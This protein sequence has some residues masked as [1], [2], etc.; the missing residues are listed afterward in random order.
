MNA[1][2]VKIPQT[3]HYCWF[4]KG[5]LPPLAQ[6]CISSWRKYF[7]EYQIKEW[8][9]DNF[10]VSRI[11]YSAEAYLEKKYAF[12]S[13]YARFWILY[14]YG[15]IY[16]DTDVEVIKPMNEVIDKGPFMGCENDNPVT[17]A[18]GLGI[19][20][21]PGHILC[22]EILDLYEKQHFIENGR[23]NLTTV[24]TYMMQILMRHGLRNEPVIQ[25]VDGIYIYPTEFFCPKSIVDG[26]IRLTGNS[27]TIHHYDQSW[28]SP[29]RKYGR[30]FVLL[31][32]GKNLKSALKHLLRFK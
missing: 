23:Q 11:A 4:G 27:Y 10:D 26:K 3:I 28:Q 12:V 7:P 6:K 15:G 31:L 30:Q 22:K 1:E 29:I 9:E 18:P 13:D 2:T 8:N 14:N 25:N 20:V 24:V 17:V 21:H 32:G 5:K 16:F 19:G